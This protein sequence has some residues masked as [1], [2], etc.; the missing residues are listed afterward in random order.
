MNLGPF[1]VEKSYSHTSLAM[2]LDQ[3]SQYINPNHNFLSPMGNF[4]HTHTHI[5][6]YIYIYI[7]IRIGFACTC[8]LL[9]L[10]ESAHDLIL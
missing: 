7:Y 8:N 6:I 4:V 5:Y 9:V 10:L 2:G 3:L 1:S